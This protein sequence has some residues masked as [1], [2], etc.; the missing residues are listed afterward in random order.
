M[1]L[2]VCRAAPETIR[3]R[4]EGRHGDASDADWGVYLQ[5]A[6]SWEEPGPETVPLLTMIPTDQ[7]PEQAAARALGALRTA[8]VA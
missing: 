7:S 6:G 3:G 5:A 1:A 2:L 8:G 4:L